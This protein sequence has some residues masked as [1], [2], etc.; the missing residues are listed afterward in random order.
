MRDDAAPDTASLVVLGRMASMQVEIPPSLGPCR[1]RVSVGSSRRWVFLAQESA[2]TQERKEQ[3]SGECGH[4]CLEE[5]D[6]KG[7]FGRDANSLRVEGC[8]S[9]TP[10]ESARRIHRRADPDAEERC[11]GLVVCN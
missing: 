2:G 3:F 9:F 6:P 1:A 11:P 7:D 5:E 10:A 4:P 8:L